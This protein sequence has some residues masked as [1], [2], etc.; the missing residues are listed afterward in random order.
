MR[1]LAGLAAMAALMIAQVVFSPGNYKGSYTGGAGSGDF[2]IELKVDGK[3]G[4]AA[5]VGFTNMG[6]EVPGKVTA[7]KIRG[8]K[9]EMA[10]DVD[11]QGAKLTSSAEGTIKGATIEGTYKTTAEGQAVDQGSWKAT[12]NRAQR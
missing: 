3:G 6:E 5:T 4:M 1:I 9:I 8:Y 7:L 11:L 10:Y 2:H 12:L